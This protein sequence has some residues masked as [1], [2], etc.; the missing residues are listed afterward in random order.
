MSDRFAS[1]LTAAVLI[2]GTALH[3][4]AYFARPSF[5]YDEAYL[6]LN[7]RDRGYAELLGPTL[8]AQA[9]PPLFM[10]ALRLLYDV[11]GM[12]ELAMRFVPMVAGLLSLYVAVPLGR[13]AVAG[14]GRVF[15][16]V[17]AAASIHLLK[18]SNDVKP[19]SLDVLMTELI[20]WAGVVYLA[21]TSQPR[22]RKAEAGLLLLG[23]A[24]PWASYPAAF[25]LA[26]VGLAWFVACV[27]RPDRHTILGFA[28]YVV[29]GAASAAGLYVAAV[30][31]QRTDTLTDYWK[32][33]FLDGSSGQAAV[34]SFFRT[35]YQAA[36]YH[37]TGLGVVFLI[38]CP[39]GCA[40]LWRRRPEMALAVGGG[41]PFLLAANLLKLYPIYGRLMMFAAPVT[42]VLASA[43]LGDALARLR[44]RWRWAAFAAFLLLPLPDAVRSVKLAATGGQ[45]MPQFRE[46]YEHLNARRQ[47]AD[48]VYHAMPEP[49][50]VYHGRQENGYDTTTPAETVIARAAGRRLWLVSPPDRSAAG[51]PK[52]AD[53]DAK[54]T[55][56]GFR[57]THDAAFFGVVV[58]AYEPGK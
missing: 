28:L 5:W 41:L 56:A 21:P 2:F 34:T 22:S 13:V 8:N 6:L 20:L 16:V 24:A 43:A 17:F 44:G 19:Y 45:A 32:F 10:W 37:T 54:L 23:V 12:G 27:R 1:R 15:P 7:I 4:A 55:A 33:G 57:K 18:L 9:A 31:H 53:W 26:G 30:R 35:A 51:L 48:V 47:P 39:F 42:W 25:A 46:A 3:L 49:F 14:P 36:D 38:L 40:A 29:S 11:F 50:M 58:S 52:L